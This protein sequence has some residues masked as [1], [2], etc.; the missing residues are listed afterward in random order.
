MT[1]VTS[2]SHPIPPEW[3]AHMRTPPDKR[4]RA[5]KLGIVVASVVVVAIGAMF[6]F[7]SR[8]SP[9]VGDCAEPRSKS[10]DDYDLV[11]V[12]CAAPKAAY[13]VGYSETS[14]NPRCPDGDYFADTGRSGR[15]STR[16]L[17]KCFMLNVNEGECLKLDTYRAAKLYSKV[18][19]GPSVEKVTK[20]VRGKADA[21]ACAAPATPRVY[22]E[23]A[24][25][26][27]LTAT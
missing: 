22:S 5:T 17:R 25:T 3:Q 18:A 24:T 10:R 19:C 14:V 4:R 23:P 16:K 11:K 2:S 21:T 27:C 15:K 26:V 9:G 13:K 20:V 6:F 8:T 7:I 12:D 1:G